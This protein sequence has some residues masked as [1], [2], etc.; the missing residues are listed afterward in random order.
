MDIT[1]RTIALRNKCDDFP[2]FICNF[3][4]NDYDCL[5]EYDRHVRE[6]I[7]ERPAP[8]LNDIIH[9]NN[10]RLGLTAELEDNYD[11]NERVLHMTVKLNWPKKYELQPLDKMSSQLSGRIASEWTGDEWQYLDRCYSVWGN[12]T[13]Q[14]EDV[15]WWLPRMTMDDNVR[16]TLNRAAMN[17]MFLLFDYG[18]QMNRILRDGLAPLD[19]D[20]IWARGLDSQNYPKFEPGY[21]AMQIQLRNYLRM[22]ERHWTKVVVPYFGGNPTK[23]TKYDPVYDGSLEALLRS[24]DR[25]MFDIRRPEAVG[26]ECDAELLG[27]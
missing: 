16:V 10:F 25:R 11:T 2:D 17:N 1:R 19:W 23:F 27:F 15:E 9:Y 13:I 6:F 5:G 3:G 18:R 24:I 26:V 14:M 20:I 8:V 7:D 12:M 21:E 4:V 22:I